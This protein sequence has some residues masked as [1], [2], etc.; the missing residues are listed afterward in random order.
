MASERVIKS[1][2]TLQM[3][4]YINGMKAAG[5]ETRKTA[6]EAQKLANQGEAFGKLGAAAVA[7]GAFVAVGLGVAVSKFADFDE[8]MS[9][10]QAATQVSRE[11]MDLLRD[12]ALEAGASTVFSATEAANAVEELGKAG[13]STAQILNGGLDTALSLAAAGQL[14]VAR[15]AEIAAVTMKQFNLESEDLP[16]VADLLAAGAGKAAGD[17][18]DLAQA[19]NQ[20]ALVANAAGLTIEETTGTLSAFADAGLLGSDAG[21]SFKSMLQRLTPVSQESADEME[22]LGISAYDAQGNFV[23]ASE[24]A[25]VL[26]TQLKDLTTEQRNAALAQIFGSDAVRAANVLYEEGADGI[27]K[28]IDQTNDS[29]YAA[30]VA[31]DRLNNLKGDVEQ[32]GGALDTALIKTGS[33]AN[34]SLRALTQGATGLVTAIGDLPTPVLVAAG[35]LAGLVATVGLV[36][37]AALI[38]V[39]KVAQFKDSLSYLNVS[40]ASAARG[41]GLAS[42]ALAVAGVAF[43]LWAAKQAEATATTA[44]FKDSLDETT[45]AVTE[46]TREL[47]A[48][49]LSEKNA[50]ADAKKYGITQAELTDA[51]LEGGEALELVEKKLASAGEG[52]TGNQKRAAD[53]AATYGD[54]ATSTKNLSNLIG[55]AREDLDDQAAAA[56]AADKS[57]SGAADSYQEAADKAGELRSNLQEL[58]DTIMSANEANLD[59]REA[60]RRLIESFAEFDAALAENGSSMDLNTEAGRENEANLD[61]IAQAAM[62]AASSITASG[63]SY[64]EYRASLESS[65]TSLLERIEDLG[66]TGQAAEDLADKILSIPTETEWQLIADTAAAQATV[67]QFIFDNNGRTITLGVQTPGLRPSVGN[68]GGAGG[69]AGGGAVYGPG[70]RT[71]DSVP[72]VLSNGEHV[73]TAS[74]VEA[75]GGQHAVYGFRQSLHGGGEPETKSELN[76][77]QNLNI[78]NG[79][80]AEEI[81]SA[82]LR[83]ANFALR[84]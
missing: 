13:L 52:F 50:F 45:G 5:D 73:L 39:P 1:S 51:V 83:M 38:A 33:G 55:E 67:D 10:V 23:G 3:Q 61:A 34:D 64:D 11:E 49:K 79:P 60:N 57:T 43:A 27:Q 54:A 69:F 71:S 2:L 37:G 77:T 17:V 41:I 29:G 36:G 25:G 68:D 84:G 15:A 18:E 8:A 7:M 20:S 40:G 82:S 4:N 14:D 65:R 44:E 21:T 9:N 78:T 70:T 24:F 58:I 12:A 63:G 22:R 19:L 53:L 74:D 66:V 26:Q 75:M 28:Y 6:T 59:T 76:Y 72:A 48:K 32:L 16:R 62:D 42:G 47:V 31:A 35:G 80:S 81:A 46:Y 56:E 30:K